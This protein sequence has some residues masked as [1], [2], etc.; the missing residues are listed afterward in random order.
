MAEKTVEAETRLGQYLDLLHHREVELS[1]IERKRL[2][3]DAALRF[4]SP[5]ESDEFKQRVVDI[6]REAIDAAI[7][8]RNAGGLVDPKQKRRRTS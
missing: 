1:L 5:I 3:L 8:E 4:T 7:K 2:E 6:T